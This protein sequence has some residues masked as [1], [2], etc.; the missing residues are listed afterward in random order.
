MTL[1]TFFSFRGRAS[2]K[3][4]WLT[5]LSVCGALLLLTLAAPLMNFAGP[6]LG[7]FVLVPLMIASAVF[8]LWSNLAVSARRLH[9][10]GKSGWWI[11][12]YWVIPAAINVFSEQMGGDV[13]LVAGTLSLLIYIAILVELGVLRGTAG[14]NAYGDS[15]AA[16][17][18]PLPAA[19]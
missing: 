7:L 18:P 11:V 12:P 8:A 1:K 6:I 3:Q 13:K 19:I 2:R 5:V 10:R 14:P 9:D 15:P 16:A 4:Y 17:P